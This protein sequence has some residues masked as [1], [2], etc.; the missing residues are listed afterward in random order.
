MKILQVN[1]VYKKGST[2]KIVFDVHTELLKQG[3]DSVV[4]YGRG[5]RVREP[6]VYK[7][8]GEL[9]SKCNNALSRVT[10]LM[11]GGC[12]FSTNRLLRIIRKERPDVV[13]LHCI[14]GYFVN[15]Y[16]MVS[17]L[18]K[19]R[20]KTVLTL[21]AEFM[22]TANC[23]HAFDCDRWKTGCGNCPRLRKE[24]KSLFLDNTALSFRKMRKAF[25]GFDEN[26]IVTSV[27]PWLMERAKQ[28]PI[29]ADKQHCVV[30]N[31]VDTDIFHPY[32]TTE[33]RNA[34]GLAEEK[35]IFHATAHFSADPAHIKGGY[36]I[37]QLAERLK[38]EN[39]KIFV[40]GTCDE[41]IQAPDNVIFLGKITDQTLLAKYYS[42]SDVTVLT[43]QK[44]TFSMVTAESLCCGTPVAGFQAGGP[45]Q[46]AIADYSSFVPY[47]ALDALM[48]AVVGYLHKDW[49]AADIAEVSEK[50][51]SRDT[52]TE[53]YLSCYRTIL[54]KDSK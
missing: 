38:A 47:G 1:C 30:L 5:E 43:S 23:G 42:M 26:L 32:D 52:M 18:K 28:S 12:F 49:N 31:G 17:W 48:D 8:C 27:S 6:H 3:I 25:E 46:I 24:T 11:Y 22:H 44:E 16:R 36:Y 29:L 51:Y 33:L 20:L 21:H 40:A 35:V 50:K 19:Q 39:V 41:G 34:H 4:C 9:Y 54:R 45:E 7:T 37:L 15:I 13:H 2:G 53:G 14:N 10:G